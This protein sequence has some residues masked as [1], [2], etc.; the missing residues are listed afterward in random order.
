[1][2]SLGMNVTDDRDVVPAEEFGRSD[3]VDVAR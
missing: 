1:M 2:V 3:R